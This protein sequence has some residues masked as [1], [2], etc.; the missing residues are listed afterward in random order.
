MPIPFLMVM[1]PM[2]MSGSMYFMTRSMY[3][4]LFMVMMPMMMLL[5]ASGSRRTQKRRYQ[6]Q[7]EEFSRRRVQVEEAAVDSCWPSAR[8]D[9]ARTPIRR[10]SCCSPRDLERGSGSAGAGTG[11]PDLRLGTSDLPSDVA[12][13]TRHAGGPRRAVAWTAPDVPVI[14]SMGRMGVLGIAGSADECR[15]R[16]VG[17][18]QD[19]ALHSPSDCGRGCS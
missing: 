10:P 6:E 1:S 9:G 17:V 7:M 19:A 3:S 18:A 4:L 13:R 12:S 5:N 14:V 8:C 15:S 11:F 2:I 16:P